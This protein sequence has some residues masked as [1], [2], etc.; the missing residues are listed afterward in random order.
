MKLNKDLLFAQETY[1]SSLNGTSIK[2]SYST[3]QF[4]IRLRDDIRQAL[5]ESDLEFERIQ[6]SST[7]IHENIHWWQ[8]VGSNFGFL[9]SLSYPTFAHSCAGNLRNL[10]SSNI[11]YKSL[12]KFDIEYYNRFGKADIKDLNI[13]LNNYHDIEYAKQFAFDNKNIRKILED[14]RFFLNIGHCYNV[15]WSST[16]HMIST[17]IDPQKIF[18]PKTDS[19]I[20]NFKQLEKDEHEGF[21]INSSMGISPIGIGAIYEGQAI[22]NQMQYLTVTLNSNLTYSDFESVGMLHGIY[23]EAFELFLGITRIQKPNNLLDP[24]VGLFLLICDIAI[25]PN[26]GFPL[27]IYDFKNFINKNDPGIRFISI[28]A[29]ISDSPEEY[30]KRIKQYS[31]EEYIELSKELSEKIGCLCPYE[32]I[33]TVLNWSSEKNV[34]KIL[35]EEKHLA[36]S[37]EALPIRLMFSKFYRFQ[38][39]KFKYPNVLCWF[40]YHS[41]SRNPNIDFEIVDNLFK[42]HHALFID[43][44]DGEI[45]PVIF[46][47]C[48]EEN[49]MESFNEFY[50]H[51]LLYDLILK[52]VYEEGDFK[53]DYKWLANN[54]AGSLIPALKKQFELEFGISIDKISII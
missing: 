21:Y 26:N 6:A 47:G 24:C 13:I 32:N 54:R 30:V 36:Y 12:L 5:N 40:G 14:N 52:W 16:I 20:N 27:D 53:F 23:V 1:D 43:D 25:N 11:K 48:P 35:D 46:D 22:F 4:V 38:E 41:T 15:F 51:N 34:K 17:I 29:S 28:C 50:R 42:K 45:K 3:M 19:W 49:I 7:N 44:Y 2:G 33:E 8:H 18:L 10:I 31:K 37:Q 9:F 39:D